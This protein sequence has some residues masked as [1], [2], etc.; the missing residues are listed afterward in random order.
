MIPGFRPEKLFDYLGIAPDWDKMRY[1][2][3]L[4]EFF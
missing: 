1:Y 2:L 4:D 3:L